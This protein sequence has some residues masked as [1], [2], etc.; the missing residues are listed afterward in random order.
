MTFGRGPLLSK[1]I[2]F[3]NKNVDKKTTKVILKVH[4]IKKESLI[5][6]DNFF[7]MEGHNVLRQRGELSLK[8]ISIA[9]IHY[10]ELLRST[11]CCV[12][13]R[14]INSLS[15]LCSHG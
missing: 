1:K 10:I 3:F 14:K 9:V 12:I 8:S 2:I 5:C 7:S 15:V 11:W 4:D 6:S 13:I